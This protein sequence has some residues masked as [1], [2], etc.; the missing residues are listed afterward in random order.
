L[1]KATLLQTELERIKKA[2][3]AGGQESV[4]KRHQIQIKTW[5]IRRY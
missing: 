3:F 5:G 1:R 4:W 2:S